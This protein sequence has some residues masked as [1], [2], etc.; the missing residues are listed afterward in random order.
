MK[1]N[2]EAKLSK[3]FVSKIFVDTP[4][5]GIK[6]MEEKV[7]PLSKVDQRLEWKKERFMPLKL[8]ALLEMDTSERMES[9]LII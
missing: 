7:F 6:F 9:V 5:T 2:L 8:L 3:S 4:L 1:F